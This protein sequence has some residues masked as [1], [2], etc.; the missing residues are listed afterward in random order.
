MATM[1]DDI[2]YYIV[3]L[4]GEATLHTAQFIVWKGNQ[5][6]FVIQHWIKKSFNIQPTDGAST[7]LRWNV[8]H[9]SS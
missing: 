3:W 9:K 6:I 4:L 5:K 1:H 2:W 7:I 8:N